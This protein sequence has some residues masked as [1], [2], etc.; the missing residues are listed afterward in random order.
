MLPPPPPEIPR[1]LVATHAQPPDAVVE[2]MSIYPA[3]YPG[4]LMVVVGTF[5]IEKLPAEYESGDVA[6]KRLRIYAGESAVVEAYAVAHSVVLAV[7]GMLYPLETVGVN[8]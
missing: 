2:A 5:A 7:S 8:V 6:E 3:L 1:V 4:A